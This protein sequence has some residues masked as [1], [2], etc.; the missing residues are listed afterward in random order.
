MIDL[1]APLY[2]AIHL[3]LRIIGSG[4]LIA[5]LMG[6]GRDH[7]RIWRQRKLCDRKQGMGGRFV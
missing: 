7:Y 5:G 2:D 1:P 6:M 3:A 4:L